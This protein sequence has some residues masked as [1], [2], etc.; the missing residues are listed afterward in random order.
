V[1][2]TTRSQTG[3]LLAL[4]SAVTFGGAG[5]FAKPLI[6]GGLGSLHT[7]W[8][9]VAGAAVTLLPIVL[10]GLPRIRCGWRLL[11]A[12]GLFPI[13]GA[14]TCYFVA[15]TRLPVGV[16]L[17]IEYLGPVFVLTWTRFVLRRRLSRTAVFGAMLSICGLACVVE[18]WNV[19]T[20]A[21]FSPVGLIFAVGAALCQASYFLLSA[22]GEESVDPL[23][24]I[25][26]GTFIGAIALAL[27]SRAWVLPWSVLGHGVEVGHHGS[28]PG[29]TL[30]VY[31]S[32][33]STVIAYVTGVFAVRRLSPPVAS[34]VG[35]LE[36]VV[37]TVLAWVLLGEH[38]GPAQITGGVIVLAGALVAQLP[39]APLDAPGGL[40]PDH[41]DG[42]YE[43]RDPECVCGTTAVLSPGQPDGGRQN[44][45]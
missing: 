7:V 22:H 29:W 6:D 30:L 28:V 13:A 9:R 38:L 18:I 19:G 21:G 17:L 35:T 45:Q 26:V 10:F 33:V 25:A 1:P 36:A 11:L 37:A 2:S 8:L 15:I 42:E 14:Q 20:G 31:V 16:A 24:M 34:V 40:H 32:L 4:T 27:V 23:L 39:T 41:D 44:H 5:P 3:L 43:Q 12:Y